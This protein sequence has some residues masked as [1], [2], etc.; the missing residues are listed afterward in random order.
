MQ[1]LSVRRR[2]VD[3]PSAGSR[4]RAS[5]PTLASHA[6]SAAARRD[7]G[8]STASR[9]DVGASAAASPADDEG[10]PTGAWQQPARRG[11]EHAVDGRGPQSARGTPKN[12]E[13]VPKH[14]D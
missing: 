12:R 13:F 9:P 6:Q 11:Q 14:D 2:S 1:S 3:N 4:A 7:A 8:K 5:A 10:T